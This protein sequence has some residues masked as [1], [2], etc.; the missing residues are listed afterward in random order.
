M[1]IY[2]DTNECLTNNGGC[3]HICTNTEGSFKCSCNT[4]YILAADNKTCM[5]N[6]TECDF[7]LEAPSGHINTSGYPN[8]PYTSN[9]NCTWIIELP[10]YKNI[11]L[12][13]DQMA[14][15]DSPNCA[16]DQVTIVNGKGKDAI[17]LGSYCG[18]KLPPTIQSST[19]IVTIKFIS[20]GTV[21]NKGFNLQYRGVKQR[22]KGNYKF[23]AV[24]SYYVD[25]LD[26]PHTGAYGCNTVIS[27]NTKFA[28]TTFPSKYNGPVRCVY[29]FLSRGRVKI[30]FLYLDILGADCSKDRIEIY[31][32]F[33]A[34]S[35]SRRI[36]NGNRVV[37]FISSRTTVRMTYTGNSVGQCRGFHAL[38]TFL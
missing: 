10:A 24:N 2:T 6:V 33:A 25:I 5:P 20:D 23:N 14:I 26:C 30:T 35:P 9:S 22:S 17:S 4:S 34:H 36:C 38:V 18:N 19:E 7:V 12:K 1:F 29:Y 37:E 3:H 28:L 16:K 21:N 15:E 27:S 13:F 8:S 11:E 32:G 31:D